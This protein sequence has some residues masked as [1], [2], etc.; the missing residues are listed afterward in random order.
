MSDIHEGIA[1]LRAAQK[2]IEQMTKVQ[3]K[4]ALDITKDLSDTSLIMMAD[5]IKTY[6]FHEKIGMHTHG[7]QDFHEAASLGQRLAGQTVQLCVRQ[8]GGQMDS[9][10]ADHNELLLIADG[11]IAYHQLDR[12]ARDLQA[13]AAPPPKQGFFRR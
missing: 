4:D 1:Q 2:I 10:S 7:S 9:A 13:Y 8:L 12:L 11:I 5:A 6:L 3:L